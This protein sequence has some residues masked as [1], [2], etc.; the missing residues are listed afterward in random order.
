MTKE[1]FKYEYFKNMYGE[2]AFLYYGQSEAKLSSPQWHTTEFFIDH[3]KRFKKQWYDHMYQLRRVDH[4]N[5][6]YA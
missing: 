4:S 5:L 2:L 3:G 1:E 6:S